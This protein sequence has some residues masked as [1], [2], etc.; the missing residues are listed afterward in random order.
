MDNEAQT[1]IMRAPTMRRETV[2]LL[3]CYFIL[4]PVLII[5]WSV[6]VKR[7]LTRRGSL[8]SE[9]FMHWPDN[10]TTVSFFANTVEPILTSLV[11]NS[12]G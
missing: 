2:N 4:L 8:W 1:T 9:P 10:E 6:S 12:F 5:P 11:W 7:F 3:S